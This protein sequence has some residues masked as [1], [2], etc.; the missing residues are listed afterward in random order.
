MK[1]NEVIKNFVEGYFGKFEGSN[2]ISENGKLVNYGTVLAQW[3]ESLLITNQ[4]KYSR[5]TTIIQ[6]SLALMQV[7]SKAPSSLVLKGINLGCT[8]LK[9]AALNGE[10]MEALYKGE[11]LTQ[12]QVNLILTGRWN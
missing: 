11:R 5:S 3:H 4:T 2:L 12:E 8:D 9:R 6:N 7:K 1:Q 10:Y